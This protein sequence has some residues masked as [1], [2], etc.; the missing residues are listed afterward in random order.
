MTNPD[1]KEVYTVS[2]PCIVP[3]TVLSTNRMEV[4]LLQPCV[5]E[6]VDNCLTVHDLDTSLSG[7]IKQIKIRR[8][9]TD[10]VLLAIS[11][12]KHFSSR[13][14]VDSLRYWKASTQPPCAYR[15]DVARSG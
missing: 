11:V 12:V 1:G 10:V 5:N 8:N 13:R 3:V 4:P 7:Q 15:F 9:D 2:I 14:T 6:E